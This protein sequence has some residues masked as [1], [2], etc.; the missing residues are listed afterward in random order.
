MYT[1]RHS[2]S[3]SSVS[4]AIGTIINLWGYQ[5]HPIMTKFWSD[6][7]RNSIELWQLATVALAAGIRS[8]FNWTRSSVKF[9]SEFGRRRQCQGRTRNE[10]AMNTVHA[11]GMHKN[12]HLGYQNI[13][14]IGISY[15][16]W[17]E[18]R[19]SDFSLTSAMACG[20]GEW[21]SNLFRLESDRKLAPVRL[22]SNLF[23]LESNF[24]QNLVI[25]RLNRGRHLRPQFRPILI[26]ISLTSF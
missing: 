22:D 7:D 11:Y 17:W 3:I 9:W 10:E 24:D 26:G 18:M 23:R 12:E 8:R 16:A 25:I 13:I 14:Y 2:V 6:Y 15:A 5:C 4:I 19:R 21:N 1:P 20:I